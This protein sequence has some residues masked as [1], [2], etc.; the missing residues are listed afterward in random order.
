MQKIKPSK[1]RSLAHKITASLLASVLLLETAGAAQSP[2]VGKPASL[3]FRGAGTVGVFEPGV[4]L[5]TDRDYRLAECPQW[6]EGKPFLR[7][8][9]DGLNN[10]QVVEPGVLTVLTPVEQ[11]TAASQIQA[12]E[13][14]GFLHIKQP[15]QFQLFGSNAMNQCRIYQ[16]QVKKGERF[17]LRKFVVAVG[18]AKAEPKVDKPWSENRGERLYNGIVLPE[19][20]PPQNIDISD[21]SPMPVPYLDHPPAVI[22]IDVGRQLL[23]DDFLIEQTDL[24]RSF[25]MPEKYAGNPV[26]K[27][28][29]PLELASERYGHAAAVPK[30][31]GVWWDP[32]DKVFKMWYEAGWIG[33][34][35]YATSED[36]L[37]W[38]R[39]ELDIVP[40]TNQVSPDDIIPDSWTVVPDWDTQ[41]PEAR[42]TLFVQRDWNDKPA[43]SLTSADGIH[44]KRRTITGPTGD[45]STHFYNPFRQKWVYSLRTGFPGRGRSRHYYETADFMG[46]AQWTE[47]DKVPWAMADD[48]DLPD[49]EVGDRAQLYNLNAVG[50]ESLML[51]LFQ[52]HRGPNNRICAEQGLPKITELNFA[53]SRDGFHWHRPDR[54]AHIPS[55]RE[56]VWDRAYVQSVGGI[57]TIQ[58]DKLWF[59]YTGFQGNPEKKTG[60][61]MF[62]GMYDNGATGVAFLRRDG[63]VSMDAGENAGTLTTRP[64]TF[65]GRHLFVNVDAPEGMLRAEVLDMDGNPIEPFTMAKSIPVSADSTLAAVAWEGN[66]DLSALAGQPVCFRFELTDGSL[67]AFWVS[68]DESGRSDGYVAAGGPGYTGPKDTVGRNH[69]T[70]DPSSQ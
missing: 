45:R 60:R 47:H 29:T 26:L 12:L 16:K 41:D 50:Y 66:P 6:L 25:H 46:G 61:Q 69:S 13:N 54:Q 5:F 17:Q 52:I 40:G 48:L 68:Q 1:T 37:N 65:S 63:F 70:P 22:P 24:R 34:I 32:Q 21:R 9:I 14:A 2:L 44:W 4:T 27:P 11:D 62:S 42:W 55:A 19:E 8:S 36:G 67:Y 7:G 18:F 43:T 38:H 59:Y 20:W 35:A 49:P 64:V 33:K 28:E 39:P 31:G 51:G 3:D 58:G 53:Y 23:V 10:W 30:D 15:D 56:D 57:C